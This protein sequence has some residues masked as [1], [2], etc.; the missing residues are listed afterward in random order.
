MFNMTIENLFIILFVAIIVSIVTMLYI[1][2][3]IILP[4][5]KENGSDGEIEF[6]PSNQ[7]KQMVQFLSIC[8]EKEIHINAKI[9]TQVFLYGL[10]VFIVTIAILMALMI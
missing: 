1:Y 10:P 4:T 3:E 6:L 7:I 5:I 2:N 8:K 9:I